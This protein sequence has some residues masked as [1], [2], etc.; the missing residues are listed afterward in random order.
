MT[1]T[2]DVIASG[3]HDAKNSM[4]NALARIRVAVQAIDD[5]K[6]GVA[7]P[8]LTDAETAVIAAAERFSKLLSA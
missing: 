4:F 7:L 2:V 6:A 1:P 5:G 8:A 3:I